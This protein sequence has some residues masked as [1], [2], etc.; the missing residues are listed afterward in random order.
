MPFLIHESL[1][2][3]WID[4]PVEGCWCS[5]IRPNTRFTDDMD[6]DNSALP[7]FRTTLNL[8]PFIWFN[9]IVLIPHVLEGN[10]LGIFS[11]KETPLG[12]CNSLYSRLD[13][14]LLT[15]LF[16]ISLILVPLPPQIQ[17]NNVSYLTWHLKAGC[18]ILS[19]R[20]SFR[21]QIQIKN[22]CDPVWTSLLSM[23]LS[24]EDSNLLGSPLLDLKSTFHC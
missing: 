8:L 11:Q 1:S 14:S 16:K 9:I 2:T 19:N 13:F 10:N 12:L 21:F 3:F 18:L 23:Q 7:L 6:L 15:D 24:P 17:V 5:G 20:G 22:P 4:I